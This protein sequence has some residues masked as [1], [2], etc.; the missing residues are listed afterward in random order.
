M[1]SHRFLQIHES[2][3]FRCY[4][5]NMVVF[6]DYEETFGG[7]QVHNVLTDMPQHIVSTNPDF[8]YY[9]HVQQVGRMYDLRESV[10]SAA[11]IMHKGFTYAINISSPSYP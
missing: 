10:C 9:L 11:R 8:Q 5:D 3:T 6:S 7:R 4:R 2:T 1:L